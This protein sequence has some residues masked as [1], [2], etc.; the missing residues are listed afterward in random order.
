MERGL[1]F[2]AVVGLNGVNLEREA[3]FNV[4]DEGECSL[5]VTTRVDAKNPK[6]SAVIDRGELV[7]LP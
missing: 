2:G 7:V 5:L 1:E 4:I 3:L 6:A